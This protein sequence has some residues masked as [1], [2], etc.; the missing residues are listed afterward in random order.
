MSYSAP[1]HAAL[2]AVVASVASSPQ[3]R[4]VEVLKAYVRREQG[5]YV[6]ALV[7]DREGG[8]DTDL[9]EAIS[10]YLMRRVEALPPPEPDYRVEVSSA[11]L[12][13]PLL[14]PAHYRRF[15]GKLAKVIT[16]LR[17]ANRTEAWL[18]RQPELA[19]ST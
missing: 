9:C 7:I 18:R 3:F 11:G 1:I 10:R 19:R 16:T 17:I 8:V 15:S 12:D 6:L 2:E 13:R 4:D 5:A 14:T